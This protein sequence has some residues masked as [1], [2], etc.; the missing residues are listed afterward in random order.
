MSDPNDGGLEGPAAGTYDSE[1][2][3]VV[4]DA[5][6]DSDDRRGIET[7]VFD[8]GDDQHPG[9]QEDDR[10]LSVDIFL[11]DPSRKDLH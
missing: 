1:R 6:F 7:T 9:S 10:D 11:F 5:T 3:E 8:T 2:E 4:G